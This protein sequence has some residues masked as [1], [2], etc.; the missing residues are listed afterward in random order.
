MATKKINSKGGELVRAS[1]EERTQ[2]L[3][4][5]T[6]A[7]KALYEE[8]QEN[9][10]SETTGLIRARYL[11]GQNVVKMIA[12]TDKNVYGAKS[13]AK[14]AFCIG[15]DRSYLQNC[16]RFAEVIEAD[17]VDNL[18]EARTAGN[19]AITWSHVTVLFA[20][21]D[22]E[23]R[24]VA[25][26]HLL[27][28]DLSYLK[29]REWVR[30]TYGTSTKANNTGGRNGNRDMRPATFEGF[31]ESVTHDIT[32]LV[33]SADNVWLKED[34]DDPRTL[35][36]MS[37][38]GGIDKKTLKKAEAA[39]QLCQ[40]GATRL[41]ALERE[42]SLIIAEAAASKAPPKVTISEDVAVDDYEGDENTETIPT[43]KRRRK[44][45]AV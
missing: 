18:V 1:L 38:A 26:E 10:N 29:F 23:N 13:V 33:T 41:L 43:Q 30:E 3:E 31:V 4:K 25:L 5:A 22:K 9:L 8:M 6:T 7:F 14:M 39:K 19:N 40:A 28:N 27:D 36:A 35:K 2:V 32:K 15:E 24:E 17:E 42:F 21:P 20:I 16:R 44:A 37:A 12:E 11:Q 45:A 34:E